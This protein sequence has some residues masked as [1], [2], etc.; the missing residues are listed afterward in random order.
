MSMPHWLDV[1][2]HALYASVIIKNNKIKVWK[3]GDRKLSEKY[4][5]DDLIEQHPEYGYHEKKWL[6]NDSNEHQDVFE[7]LAPEWFLQ[8]PHADDYVGFPAYS[9]PTESA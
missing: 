5:V 8:W 2:P 3:V 4:L 7:K 6:V 9:D 1:Y